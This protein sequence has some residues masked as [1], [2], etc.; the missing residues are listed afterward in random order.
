M[1][2]ESSRELKSAGYEV[3]IL[4]LSLLSVANMVFVAVASIGAPLGGPARE[5]VLLMDAVITPIFLVDFLYRLLT[6]SSRHGY[7][8]GG[9]GWAD[10]LATVPMFRIFRIF[11]V[12]RVV[13]LLRARGPKH[14]IE[15]L[16]E[17]RASATFLL[18]IFLVILVVELAGATIYYAEGGD[19]SSNIGSAG[20]AIWWGLVTITTVG[21]GD[22]FPV[23]AGGRIIGVF[24]LFAGVGL[25]SVLTGFI[26][27]VFLAPRPGRG[28]PPLPP[29]DPAAEIHE[30]RRLLA[31]QDDRSLAIR[32]KLDDLERAVVARA[33]VKPGAPVRPVASVDDTPPTA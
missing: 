4:L 29:G 15:D 21:Y 13:R 16:S 31:E 17:A 7:F 11:R 24:L 9:W 19:P 28:A 2:N 12:F 18:T 10:L 14:F 30:V 32:A 22:R 25:F 3:F 33:A 20:D 27:N 6:A 1:S 5:V 8:V 26:A 23:T